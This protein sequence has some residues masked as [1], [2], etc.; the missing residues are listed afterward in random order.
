MLMD[1]GNVPDDIRVLFPYLA[2]GNVTFDQFMNLL[3]PQLTP[4]ESD[5]VTRH[6]Q[7]QHLDVDENYNC[8]EHDGRRAECN[9]HNPPCF[10]SGGLCLNGRT[11][12][13]D[14]GQRPRRAPARLVEEM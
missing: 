5:I 11:F 3:R 13:V 12:P 4:A 10:Y 8:G 7:Q 9:R 14:L 1:I 6:L 2:Q